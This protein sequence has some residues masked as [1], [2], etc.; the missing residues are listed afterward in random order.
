MDSSLLPKPEDI[1]VDK[2]NNEWVLTYRVNDHATLRLR[3]QHWN[4][5]DECDAICEI[6]EGSDQL[7]REVGRPILLPI[8]F[9]PDCWNEEPD[10][11]AWPTE[12]RAKFVKLARVWSVCTGLAEWGY[13]L[14]D[15]Q[16]EYEAKALASSSG[17]TATEPRGDQ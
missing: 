11:S 15:R 9:D 3:I 4:R 16:A 7:F 14:G 5:V 1:E 12:W 17:T 10:L 8:E 2:Q 13:A 6:R